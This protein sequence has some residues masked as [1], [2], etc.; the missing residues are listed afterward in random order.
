MR[1]QTKEEHAFNIQ[2]YL[3]EKFPQV[4]A[5]FRV[6]QQINDGAKTAPNFHSTLQQ[7]PGAN[8]VKPS[9]KIRCN[10]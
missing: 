7:M 4:T 3:A 8:L 1:S 9:T 5:C 2:E 6:N 10:R